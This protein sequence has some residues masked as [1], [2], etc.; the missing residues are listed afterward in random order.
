M[1]SAIQLASTEPV[2]IKG[3]TNFNDAG[4]LHAPHIWEEYANFIKHST[5][6]SV[7]DF[8]VYLMDMKL[9]DCFGK[10]VNDLKKRYCFKHYQQ[11]AVNLKELDQ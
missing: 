1:F 6:D 5:F 7:D 2:I 4:E 3:I 11:W 8:A 10:Y 9:R